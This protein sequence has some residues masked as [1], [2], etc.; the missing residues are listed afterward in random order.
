MLDI[1]EL[2]EPICQ[3]L[4]RHD[5]AQCTQ[6]CK[7]WH[8]I[9][10]PYI[11]RDHLSGDFSESQQAAFVQLVA[12]DYL[13]ERQH[14]ELQQESHSTDQQPLSP[15]SRPLAKYGHVVQRLPCA[16]T[17]E[18][19]FE[20]HSSRLQELVPD[21]HDIPS[22]FVLMEHLYKHCPNFQTE[23]TSIDTSNSRK[24]LT[25]LIREFVLPRTRCLQI[26][27]SHN[28]V[29][30]S[31]LKWILSRAS[32]LE[33]LILSVK[34]YDP[35]DEKEKAYDQE[36]PE[37][38]QLKL[39]TLSD[40]RWTTDT[41]FWPWL[42]KRCGKVE[43]LELDTIDE[44]VCEQ[45]V[46]SGITYMSNLNK[47]SITDF[48]SDKK[49]AD[50]LLSSS[51]R[52]WK[53]V[54][55]HCRCESLPT[56]PTAHLMNHRLTL[57]RLVLVGYCGVTDS[58][59]V[60]LLA[61]CPHLYDFTDVQTWGHQDEVPFGFNAHSFID[62][63]PDTGSLKRWEC[64]TSLKV[65]K[66]IIKDI[67][68]PDLVMS[69][70]DEAYPGQGRDIQNQVY[71]RLA[72]FTNLEILSLSLRV[73]FMN[74]AVPNCLE[75]SLESGLD[76]ISGLKK[77]KLLDVSGMETNIGEPEARWM[78]EQWP[79]LRTIQGLGRRSSENEAWDWL[80]Q[81]HPEIELKEPGILLY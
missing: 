58:D 20:G 68:R 72:R 81:H 33:E 39:L 49:H 28:S 47:I 35:V 22:K 6:V 79:K 25:E 60:Q 15:P 42:W 30:S 3:Q 31:R 52:G 37:T 71:D 53:E 56:T 57:Q 43:D 4:S 11:W 29:P 7:R 21:G 10:V 26:P 34:V 17:L 61:C 12:Y 70:I 63:D 45:L 75:M 18:R 32:T 48:T 13:Q 5:L 66:V 1:P 62:L 54:R 40:C 19:Y 76:K 50:A 80:K 55:L 16:E 36:E 65:L 8:R 2:D 59:K 77:L 74:D 46:E 44:A 69:D 41:A 14:R 51:R 64:E 67:P 23:L 27:S 78:T 38:W 9:V 24:D 73:K